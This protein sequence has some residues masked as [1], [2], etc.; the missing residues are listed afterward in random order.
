[1]MLRLVP[2]L[3]LSLAPCLVIAADDVRGDNPDAKPSTPEE[4]RAMFHL[5]PGFEIQLVAAEP[6]IQ[7]PINIT[8]DGAGR[9]WVTGSEMYPWPAG[10]DAAG[11]PIPGYEK[12]FADIASAFH[13]GNQ[14]PQPSPEAR[15]TVRVLSDFDENGH[16]KTIRVFADGLN[17]PSGIQPLP[18]G[19]LAVATAY[20]LLPNF[21]PN[22]AMQ[23]RA[24]IGD[25][26]I[27]HAP[28]GDSAIV[29]SI[30][31]IW[32]LTDWDGDGFA[33]SRVPLYETAG[34]LDT[35][36]GMS[37][38][39]YWM[40]GW[41]Y[42]T[43]GFRNHSEIHDLNGR[44]TVLDSGNTYRFRPDGSAFENYTH[45]QT[46]PFGLAVDPLGNFYS[47]DSHSKPV[48]MLQR[49]GY[50]EGI[51][52]QHD[53]LGFAPR[54]TDDGHGST[55]IA[56]IAYY[57]DDKFPE[58]YRGNLFNGNPVTR[59]VNRDK[60][61]WHGSTPQA[62]RQPDF[63]TSD[64]PWFRPV[65]VKL[66]PDGALWIADFYNPIIGH[67]E[68]PLGDPRR[69]HAHGRIWRI[70]YRGEIKDAAA[71]P[72]ADVAR[73]N[74]IE[75]VD[76]L[77][78][79][80]LEIRRLAANELVDRIGPRAQGETANRFL[81]SIPLALFSLES[82]QVTLDAS[83]VS[84]L[85]ASQAV[86]ERLKPGFSAA[87]FLNPRLSP[88]EN[89][90]TLLRMPDAF[91]SHSL[92][93]FGELGATDVPGL[94]LAEQRLAVSQI[95]RPVL[96]RNAARA[97]SQTAEALRNTAAADADPAD[98]TGAEQAKN[99]RNEAELRR[100]ALDEIPKVL[101]TLLYALG[102]AAPEDTELVYALRMALRDC[103]LLPGSYSAA[104]TAGVEEN[105]AGA[106]HIADVSVS[107]RTPEAA[108]FLL[109]HLQRTKLATPRTGEYLKHVA[110][111][112][113]AE[114]FGMVSELV[115]QISEAPLAQ[116]LVAADG[117]A[118]A[119]RQRGIA[120]PAE[121]TAWSQR[122]MVEALGSNDDSMLK[123]AVESVRE[124]KFDAKLA[125]LT[126][127]AGNERLPEARRIAALE[128]LANLDAARPILGQALASPST[129]KFRKR[130]AEL[131]SQSNTAEAR[132]ALLAALPTAPTDVGNFIAA[133][134]AATDAGTE[135]LL[136]TL[137]SGKATPILLRSPLVAAALEKRPQ[138]LRD[139]VATLTKDLPPEDQ[140]LDKVIA[141][142]A[143]AF[144]KA[145]PDVAH[146]AQI[147][148]QNCAVCH[149]LQNQGANI[150]P[151]L[152]GIGTRGVHRVIEDILDP[153]RNVDPLFRQTVI[154]TTDSQTVAG[155][156]AH[157]E[158]ELLV[159]TDVTGKPVSVPRAKIKSQ[160]ASKLSLMPPIFETT[161]APADFNDLL[162]FLLHPAP[163]P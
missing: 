88:A 77:G 66:G 18:H 96:Q 6:E 48:Y 55:A 20:G 146:G 71:A 10:T 38:F 139:R 43:H 23:K 50:Y 137:E 64:D 143:D 142:R 135:A 151:A 112:L 133:G 102:N 141:Q 95:N 136:G 99:H 113:P 15:D 140:R 123:T 144:Q 138:P 33:E 74:T 152:D 158:G 155:L 94:T 83:A 11:L 42:G 118:Q 148:Q 117:L 90:E 120:L 134:L 67:Y 92:Q 12:A 128:A 36:G 13:V 46:N 63:L 68:F 78:D 75:L 86:L 89:A 145:K 41:I 32:L 31:K 45:G 161:I 79:T 60:L 87:W 30:P 119:A 91:V 105:A 17:I 2:I 159:L 104:A 58:E 98:S 149:K 122:V 3:A 109:G 163:S 29:Y 157:V 16:A 154:E 150:G 73:L 132:A 8:F 57:A 59:R 160:T 25:R 115:T 82:G 80:N 61:E 24:P 49:G 28:K 147:F 39:L 34:Y 7:K 9:L 52:K 51:G 124:A 4:E 40:D 21:D 107:V 121:T 81:K 162:G 56:G 26:H 114:K 103:L 85:I 101:S 35:H 47:A 44:V 93:S 106:E 84:R 76:K 153:N 27:G 62:I 5:P 37:S 97:I 125:P 111:Y 130:A 156:N 72:P 65:Q 110:L 116:R 108:E 131:L 19:S 14:A 70:V 127:I 53:G 100:Q 1:M 54:I 22:P 126:K 129:M 69:D